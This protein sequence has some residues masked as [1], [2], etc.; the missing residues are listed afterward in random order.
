M[1]PYSETFDAKALLYDRGTAITSPKSA[2][3]FKQSAHNL[4]QE[5]I[6]GTQTIPNPLI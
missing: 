5:A 4:V 6:V 3:Q 1:V 2:A